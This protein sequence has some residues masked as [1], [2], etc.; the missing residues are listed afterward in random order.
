MPK[1]V[2]RFTVSRR[3][4]RLA[5]LTLE[6]AVALE[7]ARRVLADDNRRRVLVE[8]GRRAGSTP[9]YGTVSHLIRR[10]TMFRTGRGV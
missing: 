5:L 2:Q 1:Q 10:Q 7:S 8:W 4:L 6:I 3:A 9:A